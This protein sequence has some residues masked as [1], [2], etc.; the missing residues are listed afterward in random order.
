M[1]NV[2]MK[3]EV[4]RKSVLISGL[5]TVSIGSIMNI[6]SFIITGTLLGILGVMMIVGI[7]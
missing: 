7:V 4:I 3:K 1:I 6:N 5:I 2:K